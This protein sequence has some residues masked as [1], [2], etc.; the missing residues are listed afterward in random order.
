MITKSKALFTMEA[1]I[2]RGRYLLKAMTSTTDFEDTY[3]IS[4]ARFTG[5]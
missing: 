5:L 3:R 4:L 2:I 1:I